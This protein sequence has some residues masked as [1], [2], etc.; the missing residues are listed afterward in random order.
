MSVEQAD[1]IISLL[2]GLLFVVSLIAGLL[3]F[4]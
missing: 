1:T 4:R 3:F 2:Y